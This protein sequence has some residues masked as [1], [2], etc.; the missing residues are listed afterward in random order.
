MSDSGRGCLLVGPGPGE[1]EGIRVVLQALSLVC[2]LFVWHFAPQEMQ[3][4][5]HSFSKYL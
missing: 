2:I 3:L 5:I 4:F 1:I